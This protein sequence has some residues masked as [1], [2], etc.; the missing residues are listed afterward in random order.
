MHHYVPNQCASNLSTYAG[1]DTIEFVFHKNKPK[2]RRATYVRAICNM[3][4]RTRLT[5][6][7]NLIYYPGEVRT[8]TSDLTIMKLHVN[9][10]ISDIKLRY[11]CMYVKYF[12]LKNQIERAKYIMIHISMIPQEFVENIILQKKNTMDTSLHG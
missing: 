4:H 6:G 3:T 1:T 2:D 10:A 11:M 7:V 8:P 12:Y 9:S 5:A